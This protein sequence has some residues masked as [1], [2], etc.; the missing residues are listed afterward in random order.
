M[1]KILLVL[2]LLIPLAFASWQSVAAMAIIIS[3]TLLAAVFA[4]GM[5]IENETLKA[6]SKDE[7]YQLIVLALLMVILLGTDGI[8][9][10]ISQSSALTQGQPTIQDAAIVSLDD[11]YQ[12]LSKCLNTISGTDNSIAIEASK[13]CS[14]QLTGGGYSVSACGGF[15]MLSTPFSMSGS[16]VGYAIAEVASA[17]KII[18]LTKDFALVLFLPLGII[19][20]T[21]RFS[22]GAGGFLIAFGISAYILMPAGI[23][24]VDMLN[25]Q[26][27]SDEGAGYRDEYSNP[28]GIDVK[29]CDPCE[30]AFG[31]NSDKA[32]DA[33]GN[34]RANLKK[35]LYI[36]LL[37]A[38]L[39]P[40]VALLLFAGGLKA[41]SGLFGAEVD[42][43]AIT[44]F[45]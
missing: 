1:K 31:S 8:L 16:I 43:S 13:G 30:T 33:Y 18:T 10:A 14:C 7:F 32:V 25:E 19:L 3:M 42:V 37:K 22:R 39:G 6:L 29:K 35:Y 15:P 27:M 9:D 2:L 38:T 4:V 11:T 26:F 41:L 45:V 34:L 12:N 23:I 28:G 44:R 36:I 17:K 21:F 40:A 5:G 24:F 20:R